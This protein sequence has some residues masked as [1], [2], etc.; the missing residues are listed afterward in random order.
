MAQA[1]DPDILVGND[2]TESLISGE[3]VALD[4]RPT[5]FVLRGAG[6]AIDWLVYFV[7]GTLLLVY[8]IYP[9]MY[10][11]VG[12]DSDAQ[13]AVAIAMSIVMIVIVPIVVELLSRGKSLG[14]LAVGARIVRDDGGA[15]TFRHAFIRALVGIFE[16]YA[17]FGGGAVLTALLNSRTKRLGDLL[18]GTYSQYER[19]SKVDDVP[20]FVPPALTAWAATADVGRMPD[21]LARRI[22][23]FLRQA[24]ALSPVARARVGAQLA[25]EVATSVYPLPAADPET[26]L[27]AV[28]AIRRQREYNALMLEKARLEPLQNVLT[29]LP[30]GFP[31]RD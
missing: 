23:Q 5:G 29:G 26:L 7:G 18:A 25:S 12:K 28:I 14:K 30:R 10:A 24:S 27:T 4:L 17:T 11:I 3:A 2:D 15:I 22:S 20:L 13:G 1:S 9:I 31:S 16:V 19:V 21:R 6:L 8:V